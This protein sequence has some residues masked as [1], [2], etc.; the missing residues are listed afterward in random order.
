METG[1]VIPVGVNGA[2]G[3]M[4]KAI[5]AGLEDPPDISVVFATDKGDDLKEAV[6]RTQAEVVLDFT[7]PESVYP[8]TLAIVRAGARPVVVMVFPSR[9]VV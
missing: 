1:G 3:R 2:K 7:T 4:G 9:V 8:N 6:L 5:I